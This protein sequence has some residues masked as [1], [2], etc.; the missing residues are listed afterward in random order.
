MATRALPAKS[1]EVALTIPQC[2]Q[3][4]GPGRALYTLSTT[5]SGLHATPAAEHQVLAAAVTEHLERPAHIL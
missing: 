2:E 4:D 5:D 3:G 1:A